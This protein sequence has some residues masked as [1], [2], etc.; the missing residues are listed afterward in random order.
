MSAPL[1][2]YGMLPLLAVTLLLQAGCGRAHQPPVVPRSLGSAE[3]SLVAPA[4]AAASPELLQAR[5]ALYSRDFDRARELLEGVVAGE[6]A[7][8]H[9][10]EA[11]RRLATL[12][13]RYRSEEAPARAHLD[14]ALA[15]GV[16]RS[17]TLAERARLELWRGDGPA[18]RTAAR[19]ALDAATG[20]ADSLRAV[21]RLAEATLAGRPVDRWPNRREAREI[22]A[23]RSELETALAARPGA[24]ALWRHLLT[25]AL[26]LDDGPAAL[27]AWR[28]YY[29]GAL[30]RPGPLPEAHRTLSEVLPRWRGPATP[31]EARAAAVRAL[32]TSAHFDAARLL[33]I[34]PRVPPRHRVA[35]Q[36]EIADIV[37]YAA[38]LPRV[39]AL[40]DEYYRR[41]AAGEDRAA[42]FQAE[43]AAMARDVH[44]RLGWTGEPPALDPENTG[45]WDAW[46]ELHRRFGASPNLFARG[47]PQ[48][49]HFGHAVVDE[50]RTVEQYGQAAEIRLVVLDGMVSNGFETWAWDG[51]GATGGWPWRGTVTQIRTGYAGRGADA[52]SRL[53]SMQ[54]PRV[55]APAEEAGRCGYIPGLAARMEWDGAM[56]LRDSLQAS[57][58]RGA[59]LRAAFVEAYDDAL[60]ESSVFLHEGRHVID[61]RLGAGGAAE[62]EY[63]AKLSEVGLARHPRLAL[64][65]ILSANIGD[66]TAH[67]QANARAL[68]GV[69]DWMEAHVEEIAGFDRSLPVLIQLPLLTD[70]QLRAA[71]G[72]QDPLAAYGQ[73]SSTR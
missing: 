7:P 10:A 28:A 61:D 14:A 31:R 64:D 48:N 2:R 38:F 54:A 43:L 39:A 62:R 26:L 65:A 8:A 17:P 42:A 66:A 60:L 52:W 1:R 23:A 46:R 56:R 71:F 35:D 47:G 29:G 20:S 6:A 69:V 11:H 51:A 36:P 40:T 41:A 22:A 13:W 73:G 25:A 45:A 55:G 50:P 16:G 49:L 27:E 21:E 34:D 4:E 15:L 37:L 32:A 59:A 3:V 44:E 33:A 70:G 63:T 30:E 12:A 9:R 18:A 58:L 5:R 67:G 72:S 19:Q 68:C 24:V 53:Q 57:G